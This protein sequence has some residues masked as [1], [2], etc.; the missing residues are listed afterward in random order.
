MEIDQ[1]LYRQVCHTIHRCIQNKSV[2][3]GFLHCLTYN[4]KRYNKLN[5][6]SCTRSKAE[7]IYHFYHHATIYKLQ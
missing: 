4:V 3:Y 2:I 5:N 7:I 1:W 6:S